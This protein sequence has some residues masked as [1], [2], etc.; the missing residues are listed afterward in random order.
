L[1]PLELKIR[2]PFRKGK[3]KLVD[4]QLKRVKFSVLSL[5]AGQKFSEKLANDELGIVLLSGKVEIKAAGK[6]YSLG[7]RRDVFTDPA[8]GL[9]L[10]GKLAWQ[11]K[12]IVKSELALS[13]AP[14]PE[15][16]KVQLITPSQL[17]IH[18][19]GKDHFQR[20]VAD[21]MVTE[22]EAKNLLIGE[23]FNKPGQWS[24]YPPHRHDEHKPPAQYYLEE[25]YLFKV[26]PS[27][28]FG[29]QRVY[30]DDRKLDAALVIENN[31]V[32]IFK[33]GYHPVAAAP[34][35]ELYY[36][37]VLSGP[38]RIMKVHDDPKHAWVHNI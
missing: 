35:Y 37:W 3:T 23:T 5:D 16:G 19:R 24:S 13:Y 15:K 31:D 17:V 27:Q 12:A 34:G 30:T 10:P 8:W 14:G 25:M 20:R 32:A 18:E 36:L 21:I 33:K 1:K 7:P 38:V 6:K 2:K 9:Y 22:V 28:G 4:G 26:K 29:F 11:V